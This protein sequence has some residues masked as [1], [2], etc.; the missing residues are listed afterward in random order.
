MK[1][2][3][4]AALISSAAAASLSMA[5]LDMMESRVVQIT[6]AS[7]ASR[8]EGRRMVKMIRKAKAA[9]QRR[10]LAGTIVFDDDDDGFQGLLA[11]FGCMHAVT[12]LEYLGSYSYNFDDDGAYVDMM[13]SAGFVASTTCLDAARTAASLSLIHI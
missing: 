6:R 12:P 7:P 4:F 10:G 1:L 11:L 5:Q 13:T 9:S 2:P 3:L 8:K